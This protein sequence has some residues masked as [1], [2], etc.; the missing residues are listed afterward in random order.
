[1]TPNFFIQRCMPTRNDPLELRASAV[2]RA[3]LILGVRI[4]ISDRETIKRHIAS[5]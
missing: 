4:N 3:L 2:F 1:M 5:R